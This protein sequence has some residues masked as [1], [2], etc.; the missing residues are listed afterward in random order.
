MRGGRSLASQSAHRHSDLNVGLEPPCN[1]SSA[2]ERSVVAVN[3][4]GP[5]EE[6]C[7]L[8][9]ARMDGFHTMRVADI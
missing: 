1:A 6:L 7:T 4:S 9:L 8:T 3:S 2:L 5:C